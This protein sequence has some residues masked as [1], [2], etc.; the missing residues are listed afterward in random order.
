MFDRYTN[1]LQA[2]QLEGNQCQPQALMES[3]V[4]LP[5]LGLGVGLWQGEYREL[6]RLWLRW[7]DANGNWTPLEVEQE[8]QRTE[9][10]RQWAER[11]AE[12]L[13]QTGIDPDEV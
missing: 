8:R 12:R 10:E 2:F 11:L 9:H 1:A 13:R 7:Y 5:S 6:N 3:R 4:W